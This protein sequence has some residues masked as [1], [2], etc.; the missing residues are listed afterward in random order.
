[1]NSREY[2]QQIVNA[3]SRWD[4]VT[5]APHRFGGTEFNLGKVEIGHIHQNAMVDALLT[6][7]LREQLVAEG[8]ALPHHLL[9]ETGWITLYVR[10]PADVERALWVLRLSYLQKRAKQRIAPILPGELEAA[11]AEMQ[12]SPALRAAFD[13]QAA[14]RGAGGDGEQDAGE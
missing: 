11:L 8:K 1:M 5:L 13:A 10:Q 6:K 7:K 14:R 3:V 4:G 2:V 9:P 12:L